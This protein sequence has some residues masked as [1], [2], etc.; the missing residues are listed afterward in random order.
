MS[1]HFSHRAECDRAR[2]LASRRLDGDLTEFDVGLLR[3]HLRDCAECVE[4]TQAMER[5]THRV[6]GARMVEPAPARP[7]VVSAARP[8]R[9][10]GHRLVATAAVVAATAAAAGAGALVASH[11]EHTSARPAHPTT[12][13]EL[14]PLDHQFRSIREGKLLLVLPA[15]RVRSPHW[16]G[17]FV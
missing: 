1:F 2:E 13:A 11:S 4:V 7:V 6:R 16:R 12:I 5:V 10:S 3:M 9:R 14:A 15:P 8:R 17:I